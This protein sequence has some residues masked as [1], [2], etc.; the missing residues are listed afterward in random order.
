MRT[1][2]WPAPRRGLAGLAALACLGLAACGNGSS[3]AATP[4]VSHSAQPPATSPVEPTSGAAAKA[5][6]VA[7]WQTFFNGK[8]SIPSRLALLQNGS[9]FTAFV[10]A[11]AKTSIAQIAG[12]SSAKV[13]AVTFT[14]PKQATVDYEIL[15]LGTPALTKQH[16]TAVYRNGI[17]KVGTAS[18][19]ALV[20]LEYGHSNNKIPAACRG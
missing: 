19:C 11:E 13:A 15:L 3:S 14:G 10:E 2:D 12:G 5:A 7:N 20:Y 4:A 17:W 6:I 1:F 16:G 9:Q 18:F 8:A